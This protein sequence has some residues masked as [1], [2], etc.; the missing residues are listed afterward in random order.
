MHTEHTVHLCTHFVCM[1]IHTVYKKYTCTHTDDADIFTLNIHSTLIHTT[2]V[3]HIYAHWTQVYCKHIYIHCAVHILYTAQHSST[4][5]TTL[6][7]NRRLVDT[8]PQ[9]E[10]PFPSRSSRP[11]TNP[12]HFTD[13][14]VGSTGVLSLREYKS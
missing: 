7:Y 14:W 13:L 4:N 10:T 9:F 8:N 11:F 2:Y 1:C 5:K 12:P 6:L 3:R